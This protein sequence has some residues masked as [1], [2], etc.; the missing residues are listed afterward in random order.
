[1][2]LIM[3]FYD[4]ISAVGICLGGDTEDKRPCYLKGGKHTNEKWADARIIWRFPCKFQ[5]AAMFCDN[6]KVLSDYR[7]KVYAN[8]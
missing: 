2:I 5:G 4:L 8:I 7:M 6:A 3:D 1:M